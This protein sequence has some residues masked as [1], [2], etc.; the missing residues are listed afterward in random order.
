MVAELRVY[1]LPAKKFQARLTADA[2]LVVQIAALEAETLRAQAEAKRM[3][4]EAWRTANATERAKM[5]LR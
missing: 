5:N 3:R 1:G 4:F 2:S